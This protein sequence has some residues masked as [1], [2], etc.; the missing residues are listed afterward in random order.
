MKNTA[1]A[2]SG[3]KS[4][5]PTELEGQ[6]QRIDPIILVTLQMIIGELIIYIKVL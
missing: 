1:L 2:P 4:S 3:L 5:M 6:K